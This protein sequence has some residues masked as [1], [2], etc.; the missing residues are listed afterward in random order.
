MPDRKL[1]ILALTALFVAFPTAHMMDMGYALFSLEVFAVTAVFAAAGFLLGLVTA[2]WPMVYAALLGFGIASFAAVYWIENPKIELL[3]TLAALLAVP[4]LVKRHE[5]AVLPGI[6]AF[7]VFWSVSLVLQPVKILVDPPLSQGVAGDSRNLPQF[8]HIIM[9]EQMSPDAFPDTI[10]PGHPAGNI[11]KSYQDRGFDVY[12]KAMSSSEDTRVSISALMSLRNDTNN[13]RR[14]RGGLYSWEIVD[15]AEEKALVTAGYRIVEVQSDYLRF[16][17]AGPATSCHNHTRADSMQAL[18]KPEFSSGFRIGVAFLALDEGYEAKDS[19]RTF[20]LYGGMK[21]YLA[22]FVP[23][24][25][26]GYFSRSPAMVDIMDQVNREL[27]QSREGSALILHVLLPHFPY[28]LDGNCAVKPVADWRVPPRFDA[29]ADRD[30]VYRAYW[31]QSACANRLVLGLI[32]DVQATPLGREAIIFVHGDHGS[33]I[34]RKT[35]KSNNAENRLSFL[36]VKSKAATGKLFADEVSLQ[37]QFAERFREALS[38]EAKSAAY[39]V[40]TGFSP[41]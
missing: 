32:D 3:M 15:N 11:L 4:V 24:R 41:R 7:F 18:A 13:H 2:R 31:D 35:E 17:T 29:N 10:A 9:D 6:V 25:Y 36:A 8:I 19:V 37:L 38:P 26:L 23:P 22:R 39:R 27:V 14:K 21:K 28:M 40:G 34:G 5:K 20:A 33:R 16:C 12:A 1:R 30:S